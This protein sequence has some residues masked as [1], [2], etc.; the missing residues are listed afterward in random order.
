MLQYSCLFLISSQMQNIYKSMERWMR[1]FE[2]V[3]VGIFLWI[4]INHWVT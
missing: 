3:S 2:G 4:E 1:A